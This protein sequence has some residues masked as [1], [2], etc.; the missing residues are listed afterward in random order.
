MRQESCR[1]LSSQNTVATLPTTL[2]KATG[3]PA[4]TCKVYTSW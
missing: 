4:I 1:Y 3:T 2:Q